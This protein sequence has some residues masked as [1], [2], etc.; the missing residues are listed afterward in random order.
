MFRKNQCGERWDMLKSERRELI[1][2]LLQ[3][4]KSMLPKELAK[5]AFSSYSSVRRDLEELENEGF[6]IREYGRV[7]LANNNPML[8]AYPVRIGKSSA[9]KQLMAKKAAALVKEGDTIFIDA[10][11]SCSYF[12]K[13]LVSKKG[14]TVITNNVEIVYFMTQYN[15]K[16]LC[17]GGVQTEP[18]R[19]ALVGS[20]AERAFAKVHADWMFFSTRSLTDDGQLFDV[21]YDETAIR[22]TMLKNA[23]KHVFLCDSS[24]IGTISTYKQCTLAEV[25]IL[26]SDS[27]V[28]AGYKDR[29]K[30][31]TV[32]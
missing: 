4:N 15:V 3:S 7:Q 21:H 16:V 12:A 5:R 30:G 8:V 22:K 28:A 32:L 27:A 10:S 6:V 29:F 1:L 19:F 24:K 25:D 17:S 9:Q 31:L 11:S 2:E 14:I 20:D 18:N 23:E 13:E 26:V